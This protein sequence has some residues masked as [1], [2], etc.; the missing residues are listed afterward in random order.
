MVEKIEQLAGDVSGQT[1]AVLGLSF[2]PETDDMRESPAG[3]IIHALG[4]DY[5]GVGR[6]TELRRDRQTE[7]ASERLALAGV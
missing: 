6:G 3:D 7:D 4:F 5:V 2:K 1:I